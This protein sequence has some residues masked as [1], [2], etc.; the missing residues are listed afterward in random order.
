MAGDTRG[1]DTYT[2]VREGAH[3]GAPVPLSDVDISATNA[4]A[5]AQ[6]GD[7]A[8]FTS[9]KSWSHSFW[10]V[11]KLFLSLT[12]ALA[13]LW[14]ARHNS[15]PLAQWALNWA[16]VQVSE[17]LSAP[18]LQVPMLCITLPLAWRSIARFNLKAPRG[19]RPPAAGDLGRESIRVGRLRVCRSPS[20]DDLGSPAAGDLGIT[21]HSGSG[22][23]RTHRPKP[24]AAPGGSLPTLTH[25]GVNPVHPSLPALRRLN[26]PRASGRSMEANAGVATSEADTPTFWA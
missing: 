3:L 25:A 1:Q 26:V 13:V 18:L 17:T 10:E 4:V 19:R 8:S 7:E 24:R 20:A 15:L 9:S 5:E 16:Y 11:A 23:G 2:S 14:T 21:A 6:L 22:P 12:T